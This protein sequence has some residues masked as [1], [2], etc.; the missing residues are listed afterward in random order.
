MHELAEVAAEFD[1]AE[2]ALKDESN[3]LGLPAFKILGASWALN[4]ALR[5]APETHTVVAASAGNHGRAV[6]YAAARRGLHARIFLPARALPARREAIA[7]EGGEVVVVDGTYED[8]VSRAAREGEEPGVLAIADIGK[9]D[10]A[11]RV[12]DGYA[13]LFD[14]T[15]RQGSF[16]VLLVPVGVGALAAA[17]ARFAAR[18]GRSVIGVEPTTSACLTASLVERRLVAIDTPG[19][20]MAGLDCTQVSPA[21]WPSL[22]SGIRGTVT[23]DDDAAADAVSE[24]ADLGLSIGHSGAATLAALRSLAGHSDAADLR[25]AINLTLRSRVLL[26]ATEG[27]TDL[28]PGDAPL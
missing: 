11:H 8:A 6:A 10:S 14:E 12:I 16:D 28:P 4:C 24:L 15:L 25:T 23:V 20:L 3:R 19:S 27:R 17:A 18:H 1:L 9:S 26:I 5:D 22:R 2:V 21:A 13:T 7:S